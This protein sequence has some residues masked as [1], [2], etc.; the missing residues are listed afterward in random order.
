MPLPLLA[1]VHMVK[2]GRSSDGQIAAAGC[3]SHTWHRGLQATHQSAAVVGIA[4][5]AMGEDLG[6]DMSGR[7]MEHLLQYGDPFV[8]RAPSDRMTPPPVATAVCR[9]HTH[10]PAHRCPRHQRCTGLARVPS[11]THIQYPS[12]GP[13]FHH[14]VVEILCLSCKLAVMRTSTGV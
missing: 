13:L 1:S 12:A 10:I 9:A 5:V 14:V 2:L 6:K 7:A 11:Q 8:R 3:Y 4:V